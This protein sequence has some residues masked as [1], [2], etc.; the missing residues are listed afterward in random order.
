MLCAGLTIKE[1]VSAR[2][3]PRRTAPT[4]VC[5]CTERMSNNK[6][7]CAADCWEALRQSSIDASK[8]MQ[9][10]R[11]QMQALKRH[12]QSGYLFNLLL[13]MRRA[14]KFGKKQFRLDFNI[15]GHQV[16]GHVWC[17]FHGTCYS[18]S[19]MKKLMAALRRGDTEWVTGE[20][21]DQDSKRT[22]YLT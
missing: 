5:A 3:P 4:D 13:P 18:D 15:Q 6:C 1:F 8:V 14:N 10:A 21:T 16:C 7:L 17:E 9:D 20:K 12:Q 22:Y 2:A 11:L 19:R